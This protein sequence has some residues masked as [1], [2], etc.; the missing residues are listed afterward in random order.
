MTAA[1]AAE[2]KIIVRCQIGGLNNS[3]TPLHKNIHSLD[4][5]SS[6]GSTP[7]HTQSFIRLKNDQ[8]RKEQQAFAKLA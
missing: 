3:K 2:K 5:S 6:S 4:S 7:A 8:R 1:A